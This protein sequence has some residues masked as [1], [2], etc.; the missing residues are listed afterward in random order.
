MGLGTLVVHLPDLLTCYFAIECPG[1][2]LRDLV[3]E[4]AVTH[5]QLSA[6]A[7]SNLRSRV[8]R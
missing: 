3:S 1:S 4:P 6:P 2:P 8:Q 7:G 5:D